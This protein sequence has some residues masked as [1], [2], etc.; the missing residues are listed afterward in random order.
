MEY[1]SWVAVL[2]QCSSAGTIEQRNQGVH[3]CVL[4]VHHNGQCT[5]VHAKSPTTALEQCIIQNFGGFLVGPM[6]APRGIPEHMGPRHPTMVDHS[7]HMCSGPPKMSITGRTGCY[8]AA[9]F[10]KCPGTKVS[11]PGKIKGKSAGGAGCSGKNTLIK[12]CYTFLGCLVFRGSFGT[13]LGA[14]P[15]F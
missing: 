2:D 1:R 5:S 6:V 7:C 14:V 13:L 11:V 12:N 9:V 8:G 4:T 15:G 10:Q 3:R